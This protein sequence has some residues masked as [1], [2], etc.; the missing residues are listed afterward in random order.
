SMANA[1]GSLIS[2]HRDLD[3]FFTAL[4]DGRLLPPEQLA[5]MRRTVPASAEIRQA[6]PHLEYGL[7]LMRQPLA[8]GG[9][10]WGHGGDLEGGTVRTGFTEDGQRSVVIVASGKTPGDEQLLR[11]ERAV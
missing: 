9:H 4:F 6:F 3:T 5:Q 1:A 8:C 10:R 7:G 2:G 11:A